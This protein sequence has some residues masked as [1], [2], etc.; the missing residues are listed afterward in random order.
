MVERG[1]GA[2]EVLR[3]APC[4]AKPIEAGLPF[5]MWMALARATPLSAPDDEQQMLGDPGRDQFRIA[6]TTESRHDPD[7][8]EPHHPASDD[9]TA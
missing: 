3:P 8:L 2:H 7:T 9:R 4:R 5:P 1:S 6:S